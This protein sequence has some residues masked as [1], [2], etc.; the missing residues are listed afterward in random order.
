MTAFYG[1]AYGFVSIAG[2]LDVGMNQRPAD[3]ELDGEAPGGEA[4]CW[5][6]LVCEEC[7][8]VVTATDGH[9]PDCSL[10]LGSERL[11]ETHP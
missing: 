6:H 2:R 7:G 8:A 10:R 11:P 3:Q 4:V 9:R 5:L 1:P